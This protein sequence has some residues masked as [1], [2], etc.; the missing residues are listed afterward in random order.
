MCR[1]VTTFKFKWKFWQYPDIVNSPP[2]TPPP[3][4]SHSLG[5]TRVTRIRVPS[6]Q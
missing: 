5:A 1:D 3:A 6:L 4:L 2:Q